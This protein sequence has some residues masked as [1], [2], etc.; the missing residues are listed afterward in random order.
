[1]YVNIKKLL[2]SICEKEN[3]DI[4]LKQY[5]IHGWLN[6]F[7]VK[8]HE[9]RDYE[10]FY[11]HDHGT[12]E[13]CFHGYYAVN[14]EPSTTHYRKNNVKLDRENKNGKCFYICENEE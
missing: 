2:L 11:W 6:Y 8:M 12:W 1:M 5:Y 3:I 7:P 14:A 13:D 4:D 9:F 10:E